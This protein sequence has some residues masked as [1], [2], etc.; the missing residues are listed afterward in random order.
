MGDVWDSTAKQATHRNGADD[1]ALEQRWCSDG[2]SQVA[3]ALC[4]LL[5]RHKLHPLSA[6]KHLGVQLAVQQRSQCSKQG[7]VQDRKGCV[8]MLLMRHGQEWTSV[9]CRT[10]PPYPAHK[11]H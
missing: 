8:T 3:A 4:C 6:L 11:Y 7:T 9:R 10:A 2:E 1:S 5:Q